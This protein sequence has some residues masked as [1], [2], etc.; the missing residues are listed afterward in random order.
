MKV[1]LTPRE[2]ATL[3]G[4]RLATVHMWASR[5]KWEKIKGRTMTL[6]KAADVLSK[7]P[8]DK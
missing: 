7:R 8:L 4:V 5:Y 3:Y 1:Y 6:Y 2:V